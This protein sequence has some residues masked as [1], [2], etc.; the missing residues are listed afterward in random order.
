MAAWLCLVPGA[1]GT[2]KFGYYTSLYEKLVKISIFTNSWNLGNPWKSSKIASHINWHVKLDLYFPKMLTCCSPTTRW[3]ALALWRCQKLHGDPVKSQVFHCSNKNAGHISRMHLWASLP[4]CIWYIFVNNF[5]TLLWHMYLNMYQYRY[6]CSDCM[7]VSSQATFQRSA[8]QLC[9]LA[10][11]ICPSQCQD[12]H[13]EIWVFPK[14]G[15][16]QNGWFIIENLIKMD[17]LGVPL[18]LETP[19]LF[20][21]PWSTS[22]WVFWEVFRS[23]CSSSLRWPECLDAWE[24]V[25]GSWSWTY[26]LRKDMEVNPRWCLP[27]FGLQDQALRQEKCKSKLHRLHPIIGLSCSIFFAKSDL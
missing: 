9:Q 18:F 14:I 2:L 22:P 1:N 7:K 26:P 11:S 25:M 15:V 27:A 8:W 24:A 12:A 17:D 20:D 5:I 19:I 16:P 21:S 23:W 4:P 6:T 10:W 13:G 3:S